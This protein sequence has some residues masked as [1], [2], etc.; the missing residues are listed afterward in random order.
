[1]VRPIFER[2]VMATDLSPAW[3]QIVACGAELR[4]LGCSSVVL[5]YV[6]TPNIFGGPGESLA[7]SR[8]PP[9]GPAAGS[10]GPRPRGHH[11]DPYR[12]AGALLEWSRPEHG[13]SLIVIGSH[14]K[15][16]WREGVLGTISGGS[17]TISSFPSWSCRCGWLTA[18][19]P[20]AS[21]TAPNSCR[22]CCCRRIF[23]KPRP[24]PCATWS[25]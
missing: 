7:A 19:S 8:L 20:T 17:C 23:P 3:D 11:R 13:A 15:S 4:Q 24:K 22:T 12:S 1:M 21:G 14:G 2:V 18:R 5:T 25:C 16:R 10:G 6:I 9:G